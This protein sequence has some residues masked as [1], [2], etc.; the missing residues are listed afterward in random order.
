MKVHTRG[1]QERTSREIP[2]ITHIVSGATKQ[3]NINLGE[4][5]PW[6]LG[7]AKRNNVLRRV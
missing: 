2:G 1:D 4:K 3:A 5:K 6:F 7:T